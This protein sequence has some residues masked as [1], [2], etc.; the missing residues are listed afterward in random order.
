MSLFLSFFTARVSCTE[1][2]FLISE[3]V[4][5]YFDVRA[6]CVSLQFY[7]VATLVGVQ[8]VRCLIVCTVGVSRGDG[9]GPGGILDCLLCSVCGCSSKNIPTVEKQACCELTFYCKQGGW[10]VSCI[11]D[12]HCHFISAMEI[13][14]WDSWVS[15]ETAHPRLYDTLAAACYQFN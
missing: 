1:F 5:H 10:G 4:Q 12:A 6:R 2:Y 9:A 11:L 3:T 14:I 8:C 13:Y 15:H 7:P